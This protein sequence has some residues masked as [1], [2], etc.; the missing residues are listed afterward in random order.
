MHSI[1]KH[2]YYVITF[3]YFSFISD[4]VQNL[5]ISSFD[6]HDSFKFD[7]LMYGKN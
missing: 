7:S 4:M 1:F 3:Y 6:L 2:S 5:E